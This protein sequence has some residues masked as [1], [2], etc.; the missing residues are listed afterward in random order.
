[1]FVRYANR[2][3][4][5]REIDS[6]CYSKKN[7]LKTQNWITRNLISKDKVKV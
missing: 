3:Y 5:I 4:T 7:S 1:M 6:L 2:I